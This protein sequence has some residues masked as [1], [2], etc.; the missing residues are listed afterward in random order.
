MTFTKLNSEETRRLEQVLTAAWAVPFLDDVGDFAWEAAFHYVKGLPVPDPLQG[1]QSKQLF[2][3]VDTKTGRGWSLKALQLKR[4]TLPV[5]T[6]FEFI[7]QRASI[8]K[9]KK[10]KRSTQLTL[11]VDIEDT[12]TE[13]I[14]Q[15][16]S[17]ESSEEEIGQ[18][19]INFWNNKVEND[20][21]AQ[22]VVDGRLSVLVKNVNRQEY[23]LIEQPIPIFKATDFV[24]SWTNETRAGFQA[25][26]KKT[27][28]ITLKW[29]HGQT[30]LFQVLTIPEDA[31]RI[32]IIPRRLDTGRFVKEML[33]LLPPQIITRPEK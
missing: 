4:Q 26:H 21:K 30:Q 8:L 31:T 11:A 28:N 14:K 16:L 19:L 15:E 7:I 13:I 33:K 32:K 23:V 2:D 27:N 12:P 20:M 3:A 24:W 25:R 5:G 10:G 1:G 6:S 17:L 22:S 9:K 18:A 29:Y